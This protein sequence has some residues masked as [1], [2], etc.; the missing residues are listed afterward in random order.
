MKPIFGYMGGKTRVAP[1]IIPLIPPHK[2]YVEPFFGSGAVMLEKG[3]PK[4]SSSGEYREV[5]NDLDNNVTNFYE[6]LRTHPKKLKRYLDYMEYSEVMYQNAKTNSEHFRKAG[7]IERAAL[8]FF[9][10]QSSFAAKINGG[11][12]YSKSS[13]NGAQTLISKT[14]KIIKFAKRV[15]Q[16][17]IFNKSYEQIIERFDSKDTFFYFDPPY[18]NTT[19]YNIQKDTDIDY[20]L[21]YEEVTNLQ[22]EF[23]LSHYRDD[24][25]KRFEDAGYEVININHKQSIAKSNGEVRHQSENSQECI[26]LS[27]GVRNC[28]RGLFG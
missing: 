8:W 22:G 11:F 16:C 1:Q 6:V 17:H 14:K 5:I 7:D 15:K 20:D 13:R 9:N 3:Y 27:Q 2:V 28:D 18:Q 19:K 10:A 24:F 4:L 12:A 23:I 26:I 25:V 21:L